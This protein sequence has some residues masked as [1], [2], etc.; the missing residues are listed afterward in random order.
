VRPVTDPDNDDLPQRKNQSP[1]EQ[2]HG[3]RRAKLWYSGKQEKTVKQDS[4]KPCRGQ[5]AGTELRSSFPDNDQPVTRENESDQH[6]VQKQKEL[7]TARQSKKF[8]FMLVG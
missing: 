2:S 8:P 5:Q 7:A 4:Q 6:D 3:Y 1:G